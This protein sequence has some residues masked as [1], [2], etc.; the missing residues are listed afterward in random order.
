MD[1]PELSGP[2][3]VALMERYG[4]KPSQLGITPT[5]KLKLKKGERKPSKELIA[6]LFSVI[7][8]LEGSRG[9]EKRWWTG[10]DLNPGPLGCQPSA[11]PG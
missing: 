1:L 3:F 9:V 6:R 10:R 7:N 11:L 4:I 2:E 5:Y 8:Q